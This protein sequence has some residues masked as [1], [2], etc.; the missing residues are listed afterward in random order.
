MTQTLDRPAAT[1]VAPR[2][3]RRPWWLIPFAGVWLLILSYMLSAYLPPDIATSRVPMHGDQVH[4]WLLVAHIGTATVATVTGF[5]QFWPWLRNRYPKVHRWTGR[6]YFFAGV[7]PSMIL[8][9][10]VATMSEFGAAN[11]AGLYALDAMWI[12]TAVAGYRAAR[13]RRYADHRRWMVRNFA[14]TLASLASRPWQLVVSLIIFGPLAGPMYHGDTQTMIHDAASA[15][16][17][18][19]LFANV[20]IAEVYVQRRLGVPK[21]RP[22]SVA[23][24]AK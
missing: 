8:A 15:S 20:V 23:V 19:A 18:L 24:Q 1:R 21:R 4:F 2:R 16:V 17:W 10:P 22:A 5:V 3:R 7:F 12:V 14:V 6:A 13:T 11:I 9:V